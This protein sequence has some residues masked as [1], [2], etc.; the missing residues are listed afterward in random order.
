MASAAGAGG[1]TAGF[2]PRIWPPSVAKRNLA[3]PCAA[4]LVTTKSALP[5]NTVPVGWPATPTSIENFAPLPPYSV[6]VLV[7]LL[8]THHGVMGPAVMPQAFTRSGSSSVPPTPVSDT[9]L[10]TL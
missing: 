3:G 1:G 4:P 6:D 5:L 2:Q 7:A 9:R 8:A 10:V